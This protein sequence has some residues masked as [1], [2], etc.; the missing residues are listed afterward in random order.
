[1]KMMFRAFAKNIFG[2]RYERLTRNLAVY[3][4]VFLGLRTSG[5][6]VQIG[7]PVLYLMVTTVTAGVMWQ[8]LSSDDN[9]A[10]MQNLFMLPFD[11]HALV[12]S[13]VASLGGYAL[14]T[15]TAA[16]FAV[17][18]ALSGAG[19]GELAGSLLCA[20]NA[21][22]MA[23]A[24]FSMRKYRCVGFLWAAAMAA[25]IVFSGERQYLLPVLAVNGGFGLLILER[26]QGYDFYRRDKAGSPAARRRVHFLGKKRAKAAKEQSSVSVWRYLFRYLDGHKNYLANTAVMWGV[27]CVLPVF[28][29]TM[30]REAV[31]PIG[32]AILSLN[33]PVCILLSA[34]PDLE[35]AVRFLPGQ[36][37]AFCVPYCLFI[38]LFNSVADAVF[39]VS[40]QLQVG[41]VGTLAVITAVFFALQSALFSVLM[42]WFCPI[43]GWKIESDL[44]H[45]P[46]KY[47]VP[48]IM[49]LLAGI[50]A[51]APTVIFALSLLMGIE[52]AVF[53]LRCER[54][55]RNIPSAL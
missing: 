53:I 42:E 37:R 51:A 43:R 8:A 21:I 36:K 27:A 9:A 26:A 5:L 15:K 55:E 6:H 33:T 41:G 16:L 22:L 25:F 20:G 44:W 11:R 14:L 47:V 31:L 2:A 32:F 49:L 54:S 28:L 30:E 46:R 48:G 19:P 1:M 12:F 10:S 34:D 45:H 35:Q 39:L 13:C 7:L 3:L 24:V 29:G 23:A 18:F 17:V 50:V 52:A 40:W 4:T 38:F